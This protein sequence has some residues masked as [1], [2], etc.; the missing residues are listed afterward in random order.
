M[1]LKEEQ[2]DN[3]SQK[4]GRKSYSM[5]RISSTLTYSMGR[6]QSNMNTSFRRHLGES[7]NKEGNG[8]N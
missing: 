6:R 3:P 1:P 7:R 8:T 5:R 4:K 2:G